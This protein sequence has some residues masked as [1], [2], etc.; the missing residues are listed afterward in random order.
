[1]HDAQLPGAPDFVFARPKVAV[2]VDGCFWHGCPRCDRPMPQ[3]NAG[4]WRKKIDLNKERA[5]RVTAR[6]RAQGFQ[7]FRVWE[8]QLRSSA[9]RVKILNKLSSF[10]V[11][12][13]P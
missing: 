10:R 5:R 7:V 8:H 3:T 9:H 11:P 13:R 4:Y 12:S 1:M 6:L 2:F